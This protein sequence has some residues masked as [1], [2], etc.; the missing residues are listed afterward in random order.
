[1]KKTI[2]A[3]V[4]CL[5]LCSCK[6]QTEQARA[7]ESFQVTAQVLSAS[8]MHDN[9]GDQPHEVNLVVEYKVVTPDDLAGRKFTM[10]YPIT[11]G[12]NRAPSV[13]AVVEMK[14]KKVFLDAQAKE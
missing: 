1:M 4:A 12:T 6:K 8:E 10:F 13:G 7:P 11:E 9:F 14:L 2:I 5:A 3:L